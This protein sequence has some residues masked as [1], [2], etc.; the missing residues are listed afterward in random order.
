M[1]GQ[2]LELKLNR[3]KMYY[4]QLAPPELILCEWKFPE[5]QK[6]RYL[7]DALLA[8]LFPPAIA[9]LLHYFIM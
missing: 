2:W 6:Q 5:T 1:H 7:L 3:K 4:L 8:S 9:S